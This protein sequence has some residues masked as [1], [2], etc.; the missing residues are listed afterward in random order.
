MVSGVNKLHVVDMP[1][2]HDSQ[3]VKEFQ[4]VTLTLEEDVLH[5]WQV[6]ILLGMTNHLHSERLSGRLGT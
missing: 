2:G 1:G 6:E 4:G 3:Q 5:H